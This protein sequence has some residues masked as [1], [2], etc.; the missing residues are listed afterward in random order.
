MYRTFCNL[1]IA[2][3]ASGPSWSQQLPSP[4][5]E[6]RPCTAAQ[7]AAA[8]A[9]LSIDR[10]P[11]QCHLVDRY[12]FRGVALVLAPET[13]LLNIRD[14]TA[15]AELRRGV[16]ESQFDRLQRER[17]PSARMSDGH[18]AHMTIP[19]TLDLLAP[20]PIGVFHDSD[21]AIAFLDL[22][23]MERKH[24]DSVVK[25]GLPPL[26]RAEVIYL[27][28]ASAGKIVLHSVAHSV[29]TVRDIYRI[30]EDWLARIDT[31]RRQPLPPP[32]R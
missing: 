16:R 6:S 23:P 4:T 3:C 29:A 26:A 28:N 19:R 30:T 18:V 17:E 25:R 21:S 10:Q 12:S 15:F 20:A 7:Q 32:T 1:L 11:Q 2:A 22:L 8:L 9:V 27:D 31:A 5:A 24:D 13:A 14:S